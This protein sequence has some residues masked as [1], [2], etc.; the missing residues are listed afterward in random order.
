MSSCISLSTMV[1][2]A[3]HTLASDAPS[4][5]AMTEAGEP[6]T[7]TD[8]GRPVARLSPYAPS[9]IEAMVAAGRARPALR[10]M[11][12]LPEP[13]PRRL[14]QPVLS[15]ELSELRSTERY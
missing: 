8:G 11:E 3:I 9:P 10:I 7:I 15:E 1:E 4:V 6:V 14:G 5:V 2:I 12:G 13:A